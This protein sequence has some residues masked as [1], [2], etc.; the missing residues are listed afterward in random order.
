MRRRKSA[1]HSCAGRFPRKEVIMATIKD[2]A[3]KLGVSVSTV[4]KGLS[5]R[6]DISDELRRQILDTAVEMGYTNRRSRK[7]EHRR[8]CVLIENMDYQEEGQFGHGILQGF[9]KAAIRD[10]WGVEFLPVTPAFQAE[11]RYDSWMVQEKFSGAFVLGFS[12]DD[13]WMQQFRE[14]TFP[15]ILLDNYIPGNPRVGT[16]GTDSEEAMEMA[17][18]HLT[19]LGHEKIAFLNGSAGSMISDQRMLA[20]LNS[21]RRHRLPLDPNLAVYGYFVADC[22]PYHVPGFLDKG[23]TAILCG[24]DLIAQGVLDCCRAAGFRVPEDVSVIGFDDIPLAAELDLTT[25]HQSR[26]ELG[27][28]GCYSLYA[29]DNGVAVSKSLLR[30][31]LTVRGTTGPAKPRVAVRRDDDPD[32][33]RF[34]SPALYDRYL[35]R[36]GRW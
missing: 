33:V 1:G 27:K 32:S 34:V 26:T 30:P 2:I 15:T 17:V 36:S 5:G 4:S 18:D 28:C 22:A 13:P 12:L 8:F 25:I 14:T 24:N 11:N 19:R 31:Q 20:Y 10:K 35:D 3:E 21:M 29:M 23:A 7:T 9:K 6:A 16:V